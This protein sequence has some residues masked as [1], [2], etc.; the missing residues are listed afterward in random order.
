M[1]NEIMVNQGDIIWMDLDTKVGHELRG[2]HPVLVV[3]N[4]RYNRVSNLAIVCPI[5]KK[6]N[7]HDHHIKLDKRTKTQGFVL[8][9]QARILDIVAH[10]YE[11]IERLPHEI[12]FDVTDIISEFIKGEN[13]LSA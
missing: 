12:L 11:F 2:R 3:S 13:N 8:T 5:A 7:S 6:D 1:Y 4:E 9:D 10:N